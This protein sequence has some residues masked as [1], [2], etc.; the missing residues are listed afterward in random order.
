MAMDAAPNSVMLDWQFN[1]PPYMNGDYEMNRL[2]KIFL[3][4]PKTLA[5]MAAD[6]I[7][8]FANKNADKMLIA[9]RYDEYV[10]KAAEVQMQIATWIKDGKIDEMEEEEIARAIEPLF[11]KLYDLI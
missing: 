11:A 1:N 6:N 8:N 9:A 4:K 2:L 10:K 3:P 5:S 7:A